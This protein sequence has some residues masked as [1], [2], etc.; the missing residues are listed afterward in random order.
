M[1]KQSVINARTDQET[2]IQAEAVFSALGLSTTQAINLFLKQVIYTQSIP[3]DLKIPRE[4]NTKTQE[5]FEKTDREEEL[6][7]CDSL[8][9]MMNQLR[10]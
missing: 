6:T 1:S 4:L 9:D 7:E 8:E 5:T 2:K 3:F 10:S